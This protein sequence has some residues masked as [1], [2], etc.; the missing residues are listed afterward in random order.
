M[1]CHKLQFLAGFLKGTLDGISNSSFHVRIPS[2]REGF[3]AS[4]KLL[5]VC[6]HAGFHVLD[7]IFNFAQSVLLRSFY[8]FNFQLSL[9]TVGH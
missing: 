1:G 6:K 5:H 7:Y 8:R 9:F 2:V 4:C 3:T